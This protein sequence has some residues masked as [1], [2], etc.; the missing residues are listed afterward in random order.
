MEAQQ[1]RARAH[2]PDGRRPPRVGAHAS[3]CFRPIARSSL[4]RSVVRDLMGRERTCLPGM[5][6]VGLGWVGSARQSVQ[7]IAAVVLVLGV[8]GTCFL[9]ARPSSTSGRG[10]EGAAARLHHNTGRRDDDRSPATARQARSDDTHCSDSGLLLHVRSYWIDQ[11]AARCCPRSSFNNSTDSDSDKG[12]VSFACRLAATTASTYCGST[13]TPHPERRTAQQHRREKK[14]AK[15]CAWLRARSTSPT[16]EVDQCQQPPPCGL[17]RPI[18][19]LP[20]PRPHA[21]Q[22]QQQQ[23]QHQEGWRAVKAGREVP[24]CIGWPA[25]S[26]RWLRTRRCWRRWRRKGAGRGVMMVVWRRRR[27][28]RGAG[29]VLGS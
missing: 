24:T 8:R 14:R 2:R 7:Q 9:S 18:L 4:A 12:A 25:T 26:C 10:A 6:W 1:A 17:P 22:P 15:P 23:Q 19:L 5:W 20:C 27:R 28:R 3:C 16:R 29:P 11:C 21:H 13:N